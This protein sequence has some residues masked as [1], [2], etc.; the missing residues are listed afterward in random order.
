MT[1]L[2]I[3]GIVLTTLLF[4]GYNLLGGKMTAGDLMA[5]LAT[6]QTI[7]RSLFQMSLLY[8]H[9]I[10]T[11]SYLNKICQYL[12]MKTPDLSGQTLEAINGQIEFKNISFKY[13]KRPEYLVLKDLNLKLEAGKITALC[14]SSGSGKSTIAMLIE[15]LYD[16]ETGGSILLDDLDMKFFHRM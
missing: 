8:G 4:G 9:Y 2:A 3:N 12:A 6:T 5:F 7:Q 15:S 1:N 13:P 10:K 11:T 16:L 14:G